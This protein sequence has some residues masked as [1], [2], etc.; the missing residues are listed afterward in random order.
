LLS[1]DYDMNERAAAIIINN[2]SLLLMHRK[3]PNKEY[4][5]LP[6]GSVESGET[7]EVACTR[8]VK[9]ETGL[10]VT[11]EKKLASIDN[12]GRIEHYFLASSMRGDLAIGKPESERQSPDNQYSLRW[13][14]LEHIGHINLQ[15]TIIRQ[16]CPVM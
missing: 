3:K 2:G 15:P 6:G 7:P 16:I 8:E 1:D 13:I 5:V 4:Y 14:S 11:L 9:E 10:V 12:D